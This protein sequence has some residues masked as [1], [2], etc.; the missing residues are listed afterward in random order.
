M[1]IAYCVLR[2]PLADSEAERAAVIAS[3]MMIRPC[4]NE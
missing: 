3:N 1:A 4:R 2:E